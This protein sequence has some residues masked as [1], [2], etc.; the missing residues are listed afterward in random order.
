MAT[1]ELHLTR[2]AIWQWAR[3]HHELMGKWPGRDSG[4][5]TGGPEVTWSTIDRCLKSG[6]HGLPGGSS[7]SLLIKDFGGLQNLRRAKPGLTRRQVLDWIDLHHER[8]GK[9]P[10]R[11]SG[12]V[13]GGGGISWGTV[14]KRLRYGGLNLPGG[15]TLTRLLREARGVWDRRGKPRLTTKRILKW[16][17]AHYNLK[18]RW[19][20]T[21]SGSVTG[22]P[23]EDWAAVDMALRDGRRGL[24]GGSSLAILLAENR[25]IPCGKGRPDLETETIFNWAKAHERRTGRWPTRKSGPVVACRG[26]NWGAIDSALRTGSRGLPGG[27]SL[28]RLREDC[29]LA[30]D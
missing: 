13:I 28:A 18:G 15:M 14:D 21:L 27:S 7:L 26:E 6:G 17:D 5:V 24:S 19:P 8:T 11:D 20:V 16:A 2:R 25:D 30:H 3:S 9:W 10:D 29:V 12:P 4:T 22:G 1:K 23:G